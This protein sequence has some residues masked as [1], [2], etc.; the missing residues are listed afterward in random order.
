M[1]IGL[2]MLLLLFL[3][4]AGFVTGLALWLSAK[5]DASAGGTSGGAAGGMSC[6]SCGY[7][8]KGLG[9]WACPE[10][11][12]DLREAGIRPQGAP[13]RRRAGITLTAVCGSLLVLGCLLTA[14]LLMWTAAP[15]SVGPTIQQ[16]QPSRPPS[17]PAPAQPSTNTGESEVDPDDQQP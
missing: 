5:P 9:G 13:G 7:L 10:C 4:L 12:A 6:G 14:T 15:T 17:S 11:G 3:V 8:V 2:L 16:A 1:A